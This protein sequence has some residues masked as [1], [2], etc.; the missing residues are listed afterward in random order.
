MNL[1]SFFLRGLVGLLPA[2]LT[3]FVLVTGFRFL[4]QYIGVPIT[5]KLAEEFGGAVGAIVV[6]YPWIRAIVTVVVSISSIF[7]MGF[8]LATF[9][10]RKVYGYFERLLFE[11]PVV[12][13]IYPSAKQLTEFFFVEKANTWSSVVAVQYPRIGMWSIGFL[14]GDAPAELSV[15]AGGKMVSVYAPTSPMPFTGYVVCVPESE[16]IRLE[17][18][19]EDALNFVVSAGVVLPLLHK[20]KPVEITGERHET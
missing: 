6:E 4:D 7:V 10:G 14:M 1:R 11:F 18:S 13:K 16:I 9:T 12:K 3:I 19:V 20:E 8:F 17:M 5:Q 15:K 2:M